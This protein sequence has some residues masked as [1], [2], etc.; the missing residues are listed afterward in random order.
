[1][2]TMNARPLVLFAC[3]AACGSG[4]SGPADT[5]TTAD[6][7]TVDAGAAADAPAPLDVPASPDVTGDSPASTDLVPDAAPATPVKFILRNETGKTI[8]IQQGAFWRLQREGMQLQPEHECGLCNCQDTHCLV[9]GKALDVAVPLDPGAMQSW[10]WDGRTWRIMR[11]GTSPVT[12]MLDCEYPEPVPQGPL[13]VQ[14][15]YSFTKE[16][17]PPESLVGPTVVVEQTFQ[18]P[19]AADVVLI[20]R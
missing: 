11:V 20:A 6:A 5:G 7:A 3:L 14:A 13:V 16:D 1:M 17:K 9:C 4:S 8:Y 15:F 19:A 2:V 10:A 18:L 12:G